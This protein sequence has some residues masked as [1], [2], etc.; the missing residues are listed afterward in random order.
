MEPNTR[1][2]RR[3]RPAER[4]EILERFERSGQTLKSFCAAEGL[5]VATLS[6]WRRQS[7]DVNPSGYA[8]FTLPGAAEISL[9]FPSGVE[10]RLPSPDAASL[11]TL[12][13]HLHGLGGC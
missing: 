6:S 1:T 7:R 8:C 2:R 10:L 11:R 13:E 9:R 12:I 3:Y 4:E 5:S